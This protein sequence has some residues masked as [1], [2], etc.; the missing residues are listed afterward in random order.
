M[1]TVLLIAKTV[2]LHGYAVLKTGISPSTVSAV[3][4]LMKK[5]N[6]SEN[7]RSGKPRRKNFAVIARWES[8]L[9][10]ALLKQR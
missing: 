2:T 10:T 6:T 1:K 4:R 5:P 8:I 7:Y 9:G 3:K